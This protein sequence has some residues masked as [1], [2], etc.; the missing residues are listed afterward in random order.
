VFVQTTKRR[1]LEGG[2]LSGFVW[3]KACFWRFI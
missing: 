3:Q 2:I 1:S